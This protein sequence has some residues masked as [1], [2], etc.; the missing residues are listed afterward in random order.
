[1][2]LEL[3]HSLGPGYSLQLEAQAL[4]LGGVRML[5]AV[6]VLAPQVVVQPAL[7]SLGAGLRVEVQLLVQRLLGR[8]ALHAQRE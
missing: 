2:R 8:R 6:G 7:A 5:L 1:M 3:V 4:L